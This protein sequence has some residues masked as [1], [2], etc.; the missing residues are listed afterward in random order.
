M[1][2]FPLLVVLSRRVESPAPHDECD[3][4]D[5]PLA[6]SSPGKMG[7]YM[8][9]R[10]SGQWDVRLVTRDTAATT[11]AELARRGKDAIC[12]DVEADGSGGQLITLH[13]VLAAV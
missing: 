8:A 11:V 4:T 7:A 10:K 5:H 6:F 9:S 2:T 12:H 3:G 13:Q 1:I